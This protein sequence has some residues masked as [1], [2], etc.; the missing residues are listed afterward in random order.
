MWTLWTCFLPQINGIE[1][2]KHLKKLRKHNNQM[3]WIELVWVLIETKQDNIKIC[4]K[5]TFL[6]C[7]ESEYGLGLIQFRYC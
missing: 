7:E 6:D 5:N 3:P 4:C 2:K 1:N